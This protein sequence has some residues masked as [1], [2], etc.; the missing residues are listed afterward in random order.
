MTLCTQITSF[1]VVGKEEWRDHNNNTLSVQREKH[2]N[3]NSRVMYYFQEELTT[4]AGAGCSLRREA[5]LSRPDGW[6]YC[7]CMAVSSGW[8]TRSVAE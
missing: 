4:Y 3:N 1:V 6:S 8:W 7:S 2:K 5:A